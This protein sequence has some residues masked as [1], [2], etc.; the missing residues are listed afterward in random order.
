MA[1]RLNV[2]L[3]GLIALTLFSGTPIFMYARPMTVGTPLVSVWLHPH[4]VRGPY[5][6]PLRPSFLFKVGT[7]EF[8]ESTRMAMPHLTQLLFEAQ[9][10]VG[11][12]KDGMCQV[13]LPCHPIFTSNAKVKEWGTVIGW[14]DKKSLIPSSVDKP[15][16]VVSVLKAPVFDKAGT[17]IINLP[18][19]SLIRL[20]PEAGSNAEWCAMALPDKQVGFIRWSD[21]YPLADVV[22]P[23]EVGALRHLIVQRARLLVDM[24]YCWAGNTPFDTTHVDCPTGVDCSGLPYLIYYSL[25]LLI[26]RNT[27]S[28]LRVAAAIQREQLLPGDLIILR[29]PAKGQSF[30]GHA[31]MYVGCNDVGTEEAMEADGRET[32]SVRVIDLEKRFNISWKNLRSGTTVFAGNKILERKIYYA[33]FLADTGLVA[34]LRA[35]FIK[36]CG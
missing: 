17:N 10:K 30:V 24:P 19:G 23:D 26:P 18:L 35:N 4:R 25:G 28:Q 6:S 11:E 8:N 2:I 34:Q 36:A 20:S 33:S 13:S 22:A 3:L 12:T 5:P 29:K 9:V 1:I 32:G 14:V 31:L 21:L 15:V 7:P 27:D 16:G